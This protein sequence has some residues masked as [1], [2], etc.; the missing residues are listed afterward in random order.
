[1]FCTQQQQQLRLLNDSFS[2]GKMQLTNQ[3]GHEKDHGLFQSSK[4]PQL[5]SCHNTYICHDS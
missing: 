5:L 4:K 1:M 3:K 2:I